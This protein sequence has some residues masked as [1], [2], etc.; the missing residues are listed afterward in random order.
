MPYKKAGIQHQNATQAEKIPAVPVGAYCSRGH[1]RL[2]IH[3]TRLY[4]RYIRA[5]KISTSAIYQRLRYVRVRKNI[6]IHEMSAYTTILLYT[7]SEKLNYIPLHY[8]TVTLTFSANPFLAYTY[9]VHFPVATAVI[10][11]EPLTLATDGLL[12]A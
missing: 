7:L 8:G 4:L 6:N 3:I 12:L 1:R 10:L 2:I 9:I 11:P 5:C